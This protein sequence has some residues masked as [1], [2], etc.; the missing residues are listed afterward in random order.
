MEWLT[1]LRG[2]TVAIDTA[3]FIYFKEALNRFAIQFEDRFPS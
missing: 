3:P 2:H 1:R